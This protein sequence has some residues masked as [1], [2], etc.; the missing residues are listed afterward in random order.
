MDVSGVVPV[1]EEKKDD[2]FQKLVTILLS[3][4]ELTKKFSIPVDPKIVAILKDILDKSPS[5]LSS[6]FAQIL[7]DL[8]VPEHLIATYP[9]ALIELLGL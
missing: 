5:A 4:S 7:K 1:L 3:N 6:T 9:K 2:V 8:R